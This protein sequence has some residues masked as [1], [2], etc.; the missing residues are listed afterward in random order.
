MNIQITA[1]KIEIPPEI[2][3][4]AKEKFGKIKKFNHNIQNIEV[5]F[6]AEE[7]RI[8][9]ETIVRLDHH[10]GSI[11]IEVAAD[12]IQGAVDL[13]VEKCERQLRK[14]KERES[15]RRRQ[16]AANKHDEREMQ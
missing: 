9:C 15:V 5:V 16:I 12:S 8:I 4:D 13:A 14:E 7:R 10:G 6:K 11:V 1:K 2:R 3:D